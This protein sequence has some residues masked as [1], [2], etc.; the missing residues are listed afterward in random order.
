[1]ITCQLSVDRWHDY[2]SG[3]NPTVAEAI[4]DQL[5]NGSHRIELKDESMRKLCAQ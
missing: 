2:L 5:V 4:L 3:G 1:L